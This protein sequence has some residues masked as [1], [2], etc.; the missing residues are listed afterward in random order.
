MRKTVSRPLLLA[1]CLLLPLHAGHADTTLEYRSSGGEQALP[2]T[3]HIKPGL[4]RSDNRDGQWALFNQS[5]Q[6]MYLVEPAKKQYTAMD[7][8]SLAKMNA[9]ISKARR[10]IEAQLRAMPPEM[11]AQARQMLGDQI[12]GM[13]GPPEPVRLET[14]GK[15]KE[16]AGYAC[17]Q[18]RII[19]GERVSEEL[20]VAEPEAL[21]I[22]EPE[23]DTVEAMFAFAHKAVDGTGFE[24]IAM[25]YL[26][27]DG[28][29]ISVR[30]VQGPAQGSAVLTK[31]AHDD[32]PADLF[33]LPADYAQQTFELP[34]QQ[35][36]KGDDNG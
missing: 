24:G 26:N 7:A 33:L 32:L 13:D 29:P 8:A 30:L 23:F 22:S 27:L 17:S 35:G 28:V 12:P 3:I 31:V 18:A 4:I 20:C 5:E 34:T 16:V 36:Q 19:K 14:T 15:Q 2:K 9:V 21:G 11:R 10:Q 25:P 6:I 1:A